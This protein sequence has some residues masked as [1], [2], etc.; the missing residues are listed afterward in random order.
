MEIAERIK[1]L[2]NQFKSG[3]FEEVV[4]ESRRIL[5]K[6]PDNI[7][8][9]NLCGMA[10]QTLKQIQPS[11]P[12]FSKAIEIDNQNLSAMNNLGNSYKAL[13]KLDLAEEL[14]LKINKINPNYI[15]AIFNYGN[16][17]KQ[18]NDFKGAI[19]LYEKVLKLDNNQLN[20]LFSLATAHQSI[21]NFKEAKGYVLKILKLNPNHVAAHKLLSNLITYKEGDEHLKQM[22]NLVN[23]QNINDEEKIDLNFSLGKAYEDIKS[24]EK[25]F[26]YLEKGNNLKKNKAKYNSKTEI[27]LFNNIKE[28]FN[29][30]NFDNLKKGSKTP[31]IIFICGMPRSGTTLIEQIVSAHNDVSGAGELLYLQKSI[32]KHLMENKTLSKSKV[33]N[34]ISNNI[35]LIEDSYLDWLKFHKFNSKIV[36]DKAPQNFRW[37]GIMKIFFPNSKIIHCTR[38]PKD[39]CLSLYKNNFASDIMNFAYDQKNISNYYNLYS[40]FMNFWSKKLPN[41][42]YEANYEKIVENQENEIKKIIKFCDLKWDPNCLSFN[43]KNK[44]PITTVSVTQARKAIYKS[45]VNSNSEYTKYLKNMFISLKLN[46]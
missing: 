2:Q 23:S 45:S 14:Y 35:N 17:K 11:I 41:F 31:G 38:N 16:L 9:L 37:I 27:N 15:Q 34:E 19:E 39:I 44:T 10:L 26:K 22:E 33:I 6:Y 3:N 43:K 29:E 12:F 28:V 4:N 36:T 30:I 18:I 40:D 7:F 13:N 32:E 21:G 46:S 5:K 24:F 42:I 25:S 1:I 20:V 8:V